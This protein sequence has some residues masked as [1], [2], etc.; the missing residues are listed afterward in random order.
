M[1]SDGVCPVQ[2]LE[3]C[4]D[5]LLDFNDHNYYVN[6][7]NC[8]NKIFKILKIFI[9]VLTETISRAGPSAK[10]GH[11]VPFVSFRRT[12]CSRSWLLQCLQD[13]VHSVSVLLSNPQMA[14][15][16]TS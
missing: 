12:H 16:A 1:V 14:S 10:G 3:G 7:M 13:T 5:R 11:C 9:H 4:R 15:L 6:I 2:T 8:Y